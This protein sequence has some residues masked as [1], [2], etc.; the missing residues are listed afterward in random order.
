MLRDLYRFTRDVNRLSKEIDSLLPRT[1]SSRSPRLRPRVARPPADTSL[2]VSSA[3]RFV[4]AALVADV[5]DAL[6]LRSQ[7]LPAGIA[8]LHPGSAVVGRAFPVTVVPMDSAPE[9]PYVELLRSLDALRAGDVFVISSGGR[10]DVAL[11][12]E[13]L[14]TASL[15]RGAAG[16]VCDGFVR[17]VALVRRSGFAVFARGAVPYDINGR[18]EVTA[19]GDPLVLGGVAVAAGDLVVADDDGVVIVPEAV[20]AEAL[21]RAREK[22]SRESGFRK[23]VRRGMLPSAAYERFGV[24]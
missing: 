15:A 20:G 22:A 23:A 3:R 10:P 12:G 14:S 17:D 2:D 8:P 16:A 19:F 9:V 5:L 4:R 18:L 21:A 13:L 1:L 7:C 24:L 6:G 11:W